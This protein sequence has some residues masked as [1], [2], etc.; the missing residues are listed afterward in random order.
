ILKD[1]KKTY[2]YSSIS[3]KVN[4]ISNP[5]HVLC[6]SIDI[7]PAHWSEVIKNFVEDHQ[8]V[9]KNKNKS[10]QA[11][12]KLVQVKILRGIQAGKSWT[13]GYGPR[14]AGKT[15][16][17]MQI[18]DQAAMDI[19]FELVPTDKGCMFKTNHPNKVLLDGKK[20]KSKVLE[21]GE[22]ITIGITELEVGFIYE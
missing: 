16:L 22:I 1:G 20:Q 17:D 14:F 13:L 15:S 5:Q 4:E 8:E 10:V 12:E 11:F 3:I 7:E 21:G 19:C 18:F 9:L 6:L 2:L